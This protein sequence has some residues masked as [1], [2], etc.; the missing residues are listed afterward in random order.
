M[1]DSPKY[2]HKKRIKHE[3][4]NWKVTQQKKNQKNIASRC[5]TCLNRK[6]KQ[7]LEGKMTTHQNRPK[8]LTQATLKLMPTKKHMNRAERK[9][10]S[11]RGNPQ[12]N[13]KHAFGYG[14]VLISRLL[15]IIGL[16]CKRAL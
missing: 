2:A 10:M 15:E 6:S 1:R 11:T 7:N 16:F 5:R 14:V 13:Q 8:K 3:H 12:R 4:K 9:Q